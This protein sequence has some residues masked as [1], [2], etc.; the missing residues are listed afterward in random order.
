[1][2]RW[3][4][5][6]AALVLMPAVGQAAGIQLRWDACAG[7]PGA[8]DSAHFDC[9]PA[10]GMVYSLNGTLLLD[11]PTPGVSVIDGVV[12]VRTGAADLA[13]FWHF[14]LTGCDSAGLALLCV[15]PPACSSAADD[16]CGPG[17]TSCQMVSTYVPGVAGPGTGR[18]YFTL[19]RP[20]ESTAALTGAPTREFAIRL[21]LHMGNG[22]RCAGCADPVAITWVQAILYSPTGL[23]ATLSATD[24]HSQATATAG[25]GMVPVRAR[26]WGQL[27]ALYR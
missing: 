27:K 8:S 14:E 25:G 17:G 15:R 11:G 10:A 19:Y 4:V 5:A 6:T 9:N 26:T 2:I 23:V 22:A 24:P 21:E 16:F 3:I 12:D 13:P 7:D 18:L 20:D 1:M